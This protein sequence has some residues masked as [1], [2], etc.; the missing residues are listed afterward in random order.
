MESREDFGALALS[1]EKGPQREGG[2]AAWAAAKMNECSWN[3]HWKWAWPQAVTLEPGQ[4]AVN[5]EA[6]WGTRWA[7]TGP[8]E[9]VL[10]EF[11]P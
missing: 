1:L 10:P 4:E 5:K 8:G 3:R 9:Q 7:G 11:H 2:A 6:T